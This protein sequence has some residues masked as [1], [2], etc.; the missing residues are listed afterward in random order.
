MLSGSII[1]N[2]PNKLNAA[3]RQISHMKLKTKFTLSAKISKL[4]ETDFTIAR[5]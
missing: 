3:F 2:F 5:I 4:I 1:I